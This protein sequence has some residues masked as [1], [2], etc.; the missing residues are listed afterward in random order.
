MA[1]TIATITHDFL[2][3]DGSNAV[4]DVEF[5]LTDEMTNGSVTYPK[6]YVITA[7]LVNGALSQAIPSNL[8]AGTVPLV[9]QAMWQVT[10]RITGADDQTFWINVP[11]G[12][13]SV[14]LFTL[15]PSSEQVN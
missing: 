14:D 2:A 9:P 13:G 1:F 6:G 10:I 7:S 11:S 5:S 15:I 8:D 4:G 12:G 3:P